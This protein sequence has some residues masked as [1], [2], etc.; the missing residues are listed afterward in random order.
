MPTITDITD[1]II[2]DVTA[3]RAG[4]TVYHAPER[5][6]AH[7]VDDFLVVGRACRSDLLVDLGAVRFIDTAAL[8]ALLSARTDLIDRGRE[9]WLGD[10][11]TPARIT[12]ELTS[13]AEALPSTTA[14]TFAPYAEAA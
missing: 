12:M 10:I 7:V 4:T 11:S 3:D 2:A 9:L 13:I 14:A 8:S 5:F 1:A 6:D